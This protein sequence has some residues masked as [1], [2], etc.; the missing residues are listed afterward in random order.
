MTARG[1]VDVFAAVLPK[2]QRDTA[3]AFGLERVDLIPLRYDE[4]P[5]SHVLRVAVQAPLQSRPVTHLYVKITKPTAL[6]G[7]RHR[8]R[9]RVAHDFET[10]RRVHDAMAHLSEAGAVRAVACYPDDLALATEEVKGP[11]LLEYLQQHVTWFPG[12]TVTTAAKRTISHVGSWIRCF[13]SVLPAS[14]SEHIPRLIE[15]VDHRLQ[16]LVNTFGSRFTAADR[17]AVLTLL[18]RLGDQI[19]PADLHTT[20]THSD[21]AIGNILVSGERIV[22]LD[23]AMAGVGTRLHDI[24][25]LYSQL[26]LLCLK[27]QFRRAVIAPLQAALLKGF[28]A[29]LTPEHPLFRFSMVLH[30]VNHLVM[31]TLNRAGMAESLYNTLVARAHRRWLQQQVRRRPAVG[32]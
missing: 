22:V 2:L 31:V 16:R 20:A 23:F 21:M 8:L 32:W 5:F 17:E 1:A 11:T 9:E 26:E 4:R 3:L 25:R 30:R 7:D 15:Y 13:Q 14:G 29:S 12:R 28:D 27:P 6:A 10:T 18:S 19:S 24:T